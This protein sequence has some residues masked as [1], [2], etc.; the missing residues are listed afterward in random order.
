MTLVSFYRC[1]GR[2]PSNKGQNKHGSS[3]DP[4]S[5]VCIQHAP[6]R[7]YTAAKCV[8]VDTPLPSG[9]SKE[10]ENFIDM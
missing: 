7:L 2:I 10:T 8:L 9:N 3:S 5:D 1:R 4:A 6:H